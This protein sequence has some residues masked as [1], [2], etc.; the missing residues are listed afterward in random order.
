[1]TGRFDLSIGQRLAIGFGLI[2]LTVGTFTAAIVRWQAQSARAQRTFIERIA[3]LE[4]QGTALE[5]AL[6][7]TAI[8]FRSYVLN[9]DASR[10]ADYQQALAD[11]TESLRA[12]GAMQMSPDELALYRPLDSLVT[13]YLQGVERLAMQRRTRAIAESEEAELAAMRELAITGLRQF[14]DLQTRKTRLAL[15]AMALSRDKI[16]EGLL[17]GTGL[18]MI[19]CFVIAVLTARSVARPARILVGV[20]GALERGEWAEARARVPSPGALRFRAAAGSAVVRSEMWRLANA[21]AFTAEALEARDRRLRADRRVAA[22]TASTLDRSA[23]A[24]RVL[25]AVTEHVNAEVG[26][27]YWHEAETG[28]LKPIATHALSGQTPSLPLGSGI[29]GQAAAERRTLVVRDIP[30]DSAFEVKLGFDQLPP[31]CVAAEP[32]TFGDTVLGVLVV[33][34]L[35]NVDEEA[36]QFLAAAAAQLGTGLQNVNAYE[37]V[38]HLL[39]EV[40]AKSEEIQS[41]YEEIQAQNEEIQAQHEEIQAQNEELTQQSRELRAHVEQLA[42]ADA[43][44][45]HFLGVL[46]HELRNPMAP[47]MN[48]LVL[49][50]RAPSGSEAANR[51][52]VVIERQTK[53]LVR[54]IDDLLDITRISEGKIRIQREPVDLAAMVRAC[55][56]DQQQSYAE[57]GLT[58]EVAVP[59]EP[60]WVD[61]DPTRIYQVIGNLLSNAL[62]FTNRGGHVH[63]TAAADAATGE[64]VLRVRD[65]GIGMDPSLL[66]QLFQPFVQAPSGLA[67]TNA[68]LGLGLALVKAL[69]NLHGGRVEA[70]SEG[71]GKGSESV[72]QLPLRTEETRITVTADVRQ[73]SQTWRVLLVEDNVDAALSLRDVIQLDGHRVEVAHSGAEG[74]QKAREFRPHL[75]LCDIGL[76]NVDGYELARTL[77]VDASLREAFLVAL[78]GYASE[79]DR[80]RASEAGF[81]RHIAKPVSPEQLA[82]LLQELSARTVGG[83]SEAA[84]T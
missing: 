31:R 6:F 84:A 49:L 54:L 2:L 50:K 65:D 68:G 73:I 12:L 44:K 47:I 83:G 23:L 80:K 35:R 78:T 70:H 81:D 64:A 27:V 3:P 21:M 82:S 69:V 28:M 9:P 14:T 45:N 48:S 11:A 33:G 61:G 20:A 38:Q 22:A 75:V 43:R 53:Q 5:R 39:A 40:Q 36:L 59:D 55:A 76:P 51:A 62:K 26:V 58:L 56:D 29:P 8:T 13:P 42:E 77:R 34:S 4:A 79:E 66:P 63:V 60:L 10:E 37:R 67:R 25:R 46:A 19:L 71:L 7:S 57:Q 17:Y 18:L 72:V 30:A 16:G 41:Q 24:S 32:I 52:L 1:M 74:L 15:Q